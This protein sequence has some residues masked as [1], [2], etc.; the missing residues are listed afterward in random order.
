AIRSRTWSQ[1]A[2]APSPTTSPDSASTRTKY[3]ETGI[4]NSSHAADDM[5]VGTVRGASSAIR[6]G[7]SSEGSLV[8]I[9]SRTSGPGISA[10]LLSASQKGRQVEHPLERNATRTKPRLSRVAIEVVEPEG[11]V[12]A[13]AA[14]ATFGARRATW[15][16]SVRPPLVSP[17]PS[18][19]W[20]R[21]RIS[22]WERSNPATR[23]TRRAMTT[24]SMMTRAVMSQ[25]PP[26]DR[27]VA[28]R[29][30]LEGGRGATGTE[31]VAQVPGAAV[32][33]AGP[34]QAVARPVADNGD[35]AGP[36][37]EVHRGLAVGGP[38]DPGGAPNDAGTC[39]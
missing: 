23:T 18:R 1:E 19:A 13:T 38:E 31:A 16:P 12:P 2:A 30:E 37:L 7:L 26:H 11:V 25:L 33:P 24:P 5:I 20:R 39:P 34:V 28:G 29:P 15:R 32:E 14:G 9:T 6:P 36:E 22:A 10:P 17:P 21:W 27:D 35:P 4:L 3:G 8:T